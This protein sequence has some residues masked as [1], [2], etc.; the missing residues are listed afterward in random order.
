MRS[1]LVLLALAFAACTSSSSTPAVAAIDPNATV[2]FVTAEGG[3]VA[4]MVLRQL[5]RS[6]PEKRRVMVYVGAT[7]CEPCRAFHEAVER[8]EL[9]GKLG[10]VD[11]IA[12][13]ADMDAE[14]LLMSGYESQFIPSFTVPNAD[15]RAST[16]HTE[17]SVKGGGAVNDLVPRLKTMLAP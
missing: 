11:L 1:P 14:R 8:G 16:K 15:G 9:T 12:F 10:G 3:E 2:K 5:A 7:W 13:D 17:G 4:P 6:G